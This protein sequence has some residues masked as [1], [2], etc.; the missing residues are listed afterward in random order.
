VTARTGTETHEGIF[1][2][3]DET[4]AMVL[5]TSDGLRA[6]PAADVFF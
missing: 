3:I 6:I 5:R 2:T 4:G 1:D